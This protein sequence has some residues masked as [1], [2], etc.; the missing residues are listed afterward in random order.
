[1]SLF[2]GIKSILKLGFN[3]TFFLLLVSLTVNSLI[4][5]WN[6][7]PV[8]DFFFARVEG[9]VFYEVHAAS[10]LSLCFVASYLIVKG[11]VT[12]FDNGISTIA[13]SVTSV[14]TTASIHEIGLAITDYFRAGVNSGISLKYAVWLSAFFL[15][16]VALSKPYHRKIWLVQAIG[17][18]MFYQVG[19]ALGIQG[20][21]SL[22]NPFAPSSDF[23]NFT[24]NAAEVLSWVLPASVWTIPESFLTGV[25]DVLTLPYLRLFSSHPVYS[26]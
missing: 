21:T 3:L 15:I 16:A 10:I 23:N 2:K 4:A 18:M 14:F 13:L 19:F 6:L 12:N 8:H 11:L 7:D 24:D 9:P 22:S 26:E 1:M 20:T 17:L 5:N 25:W